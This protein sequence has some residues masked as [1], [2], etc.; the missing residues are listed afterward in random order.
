MTVERVAL[1]CL[2]IGACGGQDATVTFKEEPVEPVEQ[3]PAEDDGDEGLAP[4]W[5]NCP[6]GYLATYYNLPV[7]HPDVEPMVFEE[8]DFDP[9]LHD[10]WD[11]QYQAY[12]EFDASLE[13]GSNWWP[14]DD[15]LTDDPRYFSAVFNAWIRVNDDE[16]V[17]LSLGASTDVWVLVDGTV[18]ANHHTDEEFEVAIQ[19]LDLGTGQYPLEVRFA[20]RFGDSALRLRFVSDNAVVCFAEYDGR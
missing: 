6:T 7:D 17:E 10:W 16:P 13:K 8:P 11:A 19:S 20:H 2:A 5:N 12:E 1:L 9:S 15:G 14:V 3:P 4:D 18:V